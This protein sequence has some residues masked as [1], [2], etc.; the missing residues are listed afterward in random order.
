[1]T[2]KSDQ[3]A[4]ALRAIEADQARALHALR[5]DVRLVYL[6]WAAGWA[7]GFL[8]LW[9]AARGAFPMT[10]AV[11]ALVVIFALATGF[12]TWHTMRR[13]AGVRPA[14]Q[15]QGMV[16]GWGWMLSFVILVMLGIRLGTA[17][18]P[19]SVTLVVMPAVGMLIC[20]LQFLAGAALWGD[21]SQLVLGVGL[22]VVDG[23]SLFVPVPTHLLV[24]AITLGVG[25]TIC[26]VLAGRRDQVAA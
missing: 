13:V 26:A 6:V 15:W 18:L 23:I 3:A 25:L 22:L 1:M 14:S 7:L 8:G 12:S 19:G 5:I 11:V 2:E 17:D 16:Y 4:A 9:A 20:G 10:A 21:R 24:V